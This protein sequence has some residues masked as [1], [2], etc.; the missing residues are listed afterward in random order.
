MTNGEVPPAS[1]K[2]TKVSATPKTS[3]KKPEPLMVDF[4]FGYGGFNNGRL[5]P[6]IRILGGLSRNGVY[7]FSAT[8]AR[9]PGCFIHTNAV[10]VAK[11]SALQLEM[12]GTTS[13][14]RYGHI[15][16]QIYSD[17][18]PPD[19]PS[20]QLEEVPLSPNKYSTFTIPLKGMERCAKI[21]ILMATKDGNC[22][23]L[24]RNLKFV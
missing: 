17:T 19:K 2:K 11:Y 12:M 21:Q 15:I 3:I 14:H 4:G 1:A 23:V 6:E 22:R 5:D 8:R 24:M 10:K 9:D 13:A 18:D 7:I 20:V 16:I